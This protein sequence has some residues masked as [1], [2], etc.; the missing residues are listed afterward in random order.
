MN[1]IY[2]EWLRYTV[3]D[4]ALI[5]LV[6]VLAIIAFVSDLNSLLVFVVASNV[7]IFLV[8]LIVMYA[9]NLR[10]PKQLKKI[11]DS[12]LWIHWKYASG[13]WQNLTTDAELQ[14]KNE[15]QAKRWMPYLL[16]NAIIFTII[17]A[18]LSGLTLRN[19]GWLALFGAGIVGCSVFA[20]S[21]RSAHR[22]KQNLS[23]PYA[24]S[25]PEVYISS[26]GIVYGDNGVLFNQ[27]KLSIENV[28]IETGREP[29]R[30]HIMMEYKMGNK[31]I[32]YNLTIPIPIGQENEA[33]ILVNHFHDELI[34]VI[35]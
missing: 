26:V 11:T 18:G 5:G 33:S 13:E 15:E 29:S 17:F 23:N 8:I 2:K 35:E 28:E 6:I 14:T 22:I 34:T 7:I 25:K 3:Q 1:N 10:K 30:F 32:P 19:E 9:L 27:P 21:F 24:H 16:R 20:L 31:Q 4:I 12:D